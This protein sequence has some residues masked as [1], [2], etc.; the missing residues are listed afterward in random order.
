MQKLTKHKHILPVIL[1]GLFLILLF[2]I[3]FSKTELRVIS[4]DDYFIAD[5]SSAD[6]LFESDGQKS[7]VYTGDGDLVPISHIDSIK[8]GIDGRIHVKSDGI[9]CKNPVGL[10]K[11]PPEWCITDTA[12]VM[13]EYVLQGRRTLVVYIDGL[14][15]NQYIRFIEAGQAPNLAAAANAVKSFSVYPPVTD[16]TFS[17]MVTGMTPKFTGIH[18]RG[19]RPLMSDTVF[20]RLSAS[21]HKC[22]VIEGDIRILDDEVETLLNVD[23]NSNGTTDDEVAEAALSEM[24]NPPEL[25][26][27]HFHGLDDV[28]HRFGP[29]SKEAGEKMLLLDSY[30]GNLLALWEGRVIITADHGMHKVGDGG[31]H[32]EFLPD[33]IFIPLINFDNRTGR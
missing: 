27:V 11:K 6:S 30:V 13:E 26:L 4:E 32:G 8:R 2:R 24:D 17:S 22:K 9:C 7:I 20:D 3:S 18:K 23:S 16:V 33:D 10:L 28:G 12:R 14:G 19:D 31:S 1:A 29:E 21:G 25:L 15:Y 5:L